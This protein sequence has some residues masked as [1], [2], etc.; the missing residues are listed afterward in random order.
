[1]SQ[2]AVYIRHPKG[3]RLEARISADQK[4]LFH[5][6]AKLL[7][8]S[9]TDFVISTLQ[10][11]AAKIVREH[12]MLQLPHADRELFIKSLL[13]P[14]AINQRLAKAKARHQKEVISR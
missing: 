7:G 8:R 6:A 12:G 2:A 5:Q 3:E 11:A 13:K 14:P 10:E 9:L 4:N 1:M